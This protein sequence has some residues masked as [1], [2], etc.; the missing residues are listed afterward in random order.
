MLSPGLQAGPIGG[1]ADQR[2]E[3]LELIVVDRDLDADA[4]ELAFDRALEPAQVVAID[5]VRIGVELAENSADGRFDQLA[6]AD[7]LDV[8]AFDLV[9]RVGKDLVQLVVVVVVALGTVG[10][11]GVGGDP[12]RRPFVGRI[13][14]GSGL[15]RRFG[16]GSAGVSS[17]NAPTAKK[18]NSTGQDPVAGEHGKE[19]PS[20]ILLRLAERPA[21]TARP[22]G[23]RVRSVK[24]C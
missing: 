17:A 21:K 10:R 18:A 8:V 5:V 23:S 1:R 15:L 2:A 11:A 13:L 12:L 14:L 16:F 9:Q 24:A 19:P 22:S 20:R 7:R 3:N 4:T 6:A